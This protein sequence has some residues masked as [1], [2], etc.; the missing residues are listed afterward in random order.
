MKLTVP[1][2]AASSLLKSAGLMTRPTSRATHQPSQTRASAHA[3]RMG[4]SSPKT[5]CR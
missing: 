1:A 4:A 5:C 3:T 2:V